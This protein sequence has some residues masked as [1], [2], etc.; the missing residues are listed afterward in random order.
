MNHT[1]TGVVDTL[2]GISTTVSADIETFDDIWWLLGIPMEIWP[3]FNASWG[4]SMH[5]Q[6]SSYLRKWARYCTTHGVHAMRPGVEDVMLYLKREFL[7][8]GLST[9]ACNSAKSC[10]SGFIYVCGNTIGNHVLV[11]RFFAGVRK[12]R[13]RNPKYCTTW[14]PVPVLRQLN[15]WG[16]IS[17]LSMEK[18]TKRTI[19]LFLLATGQRVQTVNHIKKS[20]I[21][22]GTDVCTI[23]FSDTIKN[24]VPGVNGL[25]LH[26]RKFNG[27]PNLCVYSHLLA[28]SN[29]ATESPEYLIATIARPHT[30]PHID[31]IRRYVRTALQALGVDTDTYAPH[32]VRHASTSSF[33]RAFV[34]IKRIM[35]SAGWASPHM[36][37]THYNRPL[38]E[39]VAETNYI[40]LLLSD[41]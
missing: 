18:L 20:D 31:T 38:E 39:P 30:R 40:L 7:D 14:D 25:T 12:L 29:V 16:I 36:F 21:R 33:G 5:K 2:D 8:K 26:F 22:W 27:S 6:Y 37:M 15:D 4:S 10:L 1:T 13:P 19:M 24:L 41:V 17:S 28:Y 32:S 35:Q 3:I 11:Q 9:S 23:I 34:P